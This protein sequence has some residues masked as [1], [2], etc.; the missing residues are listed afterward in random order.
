MLD[1]ADRLLELGFVRQV[2]AVLSG[3]LNDTVRRA[4][5]SAT[6]PQG[7]AELAASVLRDPVTVTVGV[8]GAGVW[9]CVQLCAAV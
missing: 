2:D 8:K 9:L 6:M 4:M 7:I 1:E 5:F 3:C